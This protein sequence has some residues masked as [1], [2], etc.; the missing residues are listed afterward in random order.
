MRRFVLL[1]C[2]PLLFSCEKDINEFPLLGKWRLAEIFDGYGQPCSCWSP[3]APNTADIL[4]LKVNGEYRIIRAP[5]FSSVVCPGRYKLVNDSIIVMR[6]ECSPSQVG[7]EIFGFY[8]KST[9]VLTTEF[10]YPA[11][12]RIIRYRYI[13]L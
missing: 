9:K 7:P 11:S 3:V 6:A 1:F 13:K 12:G 8:S 2:L 10:E 5:V 4:E